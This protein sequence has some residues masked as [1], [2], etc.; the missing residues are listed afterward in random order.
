MA[1]KS[2]LGKQIDRIYDLGKSIKE[3]E[4]EVTELK[5]R[6]A[7]LEKVLLHEF[8]KEDIHGCKGQRGVARI[9]TAEFPS[10][11]ERAKFI[12]YVAKH[13][14]YDLFQNRIASKAYFD[15]LE[16]DE[17]VPGVEIF[18]R[19]AITVTKRGIK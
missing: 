11:K 3:A 4:S 9:R 13:K 18:K 14:A 1:K 16:N 5:Q 6:R 8:D 2:S 10:I 12:K 15:R 17:V 19:V 7:K